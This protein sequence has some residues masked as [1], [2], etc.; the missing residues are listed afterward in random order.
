VNGP[1]KLW[2]LSDTRLREKETSSLFQ[3]NVKSNTQPYIRRA[4]EELC[5]TPTESRSHPGVII[6]PKPRSGFP[7]LTNPGH[8]KTQAEMKKVT[9]KKSVWSPDDLQRYLAEAYG[10]FKVDRHSVRL[11]TGAGHFGQW[12]RKGRFRTAGGHISSDELR[13]HP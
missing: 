7:G 9:S 4:Y 13:S 6:I 11:A 8:P 2:G 3:Q 1:R 10:A 5:P 12:Q